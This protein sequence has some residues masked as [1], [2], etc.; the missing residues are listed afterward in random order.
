M[1]LTNQEK[2]SNDLKLPFDQ[3]RNSGI[4]WTI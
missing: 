3:S 1:N 2:E 4:F